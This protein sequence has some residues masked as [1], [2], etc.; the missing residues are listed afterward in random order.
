ML[1]AE[2]IKEILQ[3]LSLIFK[4]TDLKA[5]DLKKAADMNFKD[6]E[7]HCKAYVPSD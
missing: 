3:Q 1:D 5:D 6:Y 7:T 4:I 2:K